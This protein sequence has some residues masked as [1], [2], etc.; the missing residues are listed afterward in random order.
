MTTAKLE[1]TFAG[2]KDWLPTLIQEVL[3]K[4]ENEPKLV[5]NGPFDISAQ[6]ALAVTSWRF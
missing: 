3:A 6:Q 2:L 5:L 1:Q 4:Q